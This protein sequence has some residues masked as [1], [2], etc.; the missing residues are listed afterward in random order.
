MGLLYDLFGWG[1]SDEEKDEEEFERLDK[2][3]KIK[4]EYFNYKYREP[5]VLETIEGSF[6]SWW[7]F[8]MKYPRLVTYLGGRRNGKTAGSFNIAENLAKK[9]KMHIQT[10]GMDDAELP[11]FV[12][13]IDSI[14]D[15]E[16]DSILVL[17]EGGVEANSRNSMSRT[18]KNLAKL[19][20][21]ISHKEVY[22]FFCSQMG[23]ITDKNLIYCAD[24]IILLKNSLMQLEKGGER[25]V[26]IN[27]YKEYLPLINKHIKKVGSEKGIAAIHSEVFKGIIRFQLPSFWNEQMSK[28]Y[29]DKDIFNKG[30]EQ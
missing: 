26:V 22:A 11:N 6:S 1:K 30:E 12:E 3:G 21:I 16:N 18:N 20:P 19:L 2:E 9:K 15:V 5:K 28:S 13:N 29:R 14:E 8:M 23:S 17:G 10:I 27:L 4:R 25:P 7:K 24:T